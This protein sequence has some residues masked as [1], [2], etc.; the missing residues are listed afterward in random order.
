MKLRLQ[1]W[2]LALASAGAVAVGFTSLASSLPSSTAWASTAAGAH[3]AVC[4]PSDLSATLLLTPVG[5]SS[6][7]IAGAVIF[8]NVSNKPCSLHGG[9]PKVHVVGPS[10]KAISA[11]QVPIPTRHSRPVT[12]PAAG[13]KVGRPDAGSSITWSNWSCAKG[14]FALSVQFSGMSSPITVPW[15]TMTG[16]SGTPCDGGDAALYVSPLIRAKAPA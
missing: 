8:A 10:A 14:S 16:Y 7:S 6:S 15:G 4:T 5:G 1:R 12:L 13:S 2:R 3:V 11:P 9:I